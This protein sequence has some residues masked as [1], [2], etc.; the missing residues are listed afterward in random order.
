M[1]RNGLATKVNSRITLTA[2]YGGMHF[3]KGGNFIGRTLLF[4][5]VI[6]FPK[7]EL[8]TNHMWAQTNNYLQYECL[9]NGDIVRLVGT[10]IK[11]YKY[12][13]IK[14]KKDFSIEIISCEKVNPDE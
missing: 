14:P 6:S 8:I 5:D 1:V 4:T 11:Y 10:V 13:D 7:G 9:I 3:P 2:K 12:S